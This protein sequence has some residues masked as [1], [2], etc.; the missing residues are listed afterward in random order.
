[1][2]F[3]WFFIRIFAFTLSFWS[4]MTKDERPLRSSPCTLVIPYLHTL[5][6]F[7]TF[8]SFIVTSTHSSTICLWI[9]TGRTKNFFV[10]KRGNRTPFPGNEIFDM[11]GGGKYDTLPRNTRTP[12]EL[13]KK[14]DIHR[15]CTRH[16]CSYYARSFLT[17]YTHLSHQETET[18]CM[19]QFV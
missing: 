15:K 16:L 8:P 12:L 1:M 9:S 5:H 11:G 7:L 17:F 6:H 4:F 10:L 2:W 14:P 18:F 3:V 19:S 13:I